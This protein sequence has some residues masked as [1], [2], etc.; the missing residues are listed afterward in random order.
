ME[1]RMLLKKLKDYGLIVKTVNG[2]I[3]LM[4]RKLINDKVITFVR[5]HKNELLCVLSEEHQEKKQALGYRLDILRILLRRFME[6]S[7]PNNPDI[8]ISIK[9]VEERLD[10]TLQDYDYN[11]TEAINFF[12]S[13]T[14]TPILTCKCGFNPPFCSC[15]GIP[16]PGV[17]TCNK[18]EHFTPDVIGDGGGIGNCERHVQSTQELNGLLPLF[19]YA[20]RHCNKFSKLHD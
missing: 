2:N 13:I 7:L 6:H 15:G 5:E 18:C 10:S 12:N 8:K 3:R 14:P 9:S 20:K 4:P 16:I 19:R 1:A 11:L 17:I